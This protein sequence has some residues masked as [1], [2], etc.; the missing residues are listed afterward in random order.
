MPEEIVESESGSNLS[1]NG[2][3]KTSS[4]GETLQFIKGVGPHLAATFAKLGIITV[5]D[6]LRHIPRRWE[7]RTYF[8]MVAEVRSGELVTMQGIVMGVGSTQPRPGMRITKAVLT[9]KDGGSFT[10]VW[11]N[12]PYLEKTFKTFQMRKSQVVVYGHAKLSGWIL[13]I[14]NPEWEAPSEEE[15]ALSANRIVPIYPS[16]E[17]LYQERIRRLVDSLLKTHLNC[18]DELLPPEVV[19]GHSLVSAQF[20]VKNIHFPSNTSELTDARRRLVF[21]EFYCL[22]V[23][24]ALRRRANSHLRGGIK[25]KIDMDKIR[26]DIAEMVPFELTGAQQ[27]SLQD[28]AS[29]LTSG[30][31]MNRLIQG[32]VGSGKTMVALGAMLMAVESGYQAVLMAPT[33]ILAQQHAIVLR[34]LLEP[35]GHSVEIATGSLTAKEKSGVRERLISGQSRLAVG[36]HALIEEEVQFAQLGLVIIDEQHRFGVLQR[37]ALAKKGQRPHV[38]VMTATPIPRTLTMTLYGDLDVSVLNEMPPGRKPIT[39]HWKPQSKRSQVYASA[40]RLLIEGRQVYVVCPLV[41]ESEKLQVKS[42]VQLRE[43]IANEVFPQYRVGLLH[44]QMKSDEKDDVMAQFKAHEIDV[45]VATTVIEVGIDVPN[46]SAIIIEDADR[47]G[48]AQLHQLRGRVGRGQYSSYCVLIAEP[49][50]QVGRSRMEVMTATQDGFI[51]AEEDLKIRGPG[52]FFG[53]KQSGIPELIYGDIL[54]DQAILEET[55]E[56]AFDIVARDPDLSE[57]EHLALRK[58][59]RR[60]ELGFELIG[61]G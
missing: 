26:R 14:Q 37:A 12:Q 60:T 11:F 30:H 42:A 51:I 56:A 5:G 34:R 35:L 17:G 38:L 22:Q 40:Q 10:L 29:D 45:L 50:T 13:E 2:G 27:R 32:D 21:E 8:R 9:D 19:A 47:F 53:T 31:A 41:E 36:T 24:L 33:E 52:E 20:A 18:I 3:V 16:T 48:L 25:F 57:S 23:L 44:G 55:R 61:V 28:I 58:A 39:T 7:D 49:K 1:F 15:N 46:A 59:L 43:H 4:L 54:R 6:V